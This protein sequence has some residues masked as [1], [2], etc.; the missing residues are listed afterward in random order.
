MKKYKFL[1]I[2]KYKK[3]RYIA[4]NYK[5]K[6]GFLA[7]EYFGHEDHQENSQEVTSLN[8]QMTRE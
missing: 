6:L 4:Y 7:L 3:L 5:N 1:R 8:G 2:S